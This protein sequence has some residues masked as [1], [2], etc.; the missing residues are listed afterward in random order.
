MIFYIINFDSKKE[1]KLQIGL[2]F[3]KFILE[4]KLTIFK[5]L[6]M[7]AEDAKIFKSK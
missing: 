6:K 4:A 1:A 2:K 7:Y 3:I 5:S